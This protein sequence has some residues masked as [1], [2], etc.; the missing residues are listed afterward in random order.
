M[1]SSNPIYDEMT[2]KKEKDLVQWVSKSTIKL[3][4]HLALIYW[5]ILLL[6][7]DHA[8][9]AYDHIIR[10]K[11]SNLLH[12][13]G[14]CSPLLMLA[15]NILPPCYGGSQYYPVSLDHCPSETVFMLNQP[16]TQSVR[17][18]RQKLYRI[19]SS[20][21]DFLRLIEEFLHPIFTT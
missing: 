9:N 17:Y 5:Q 21:H 15:V 10:G 14:Q 2:K 6:H 8:K 19:S 4:K 13:R 11:I 20:H 7:R 16:L 1:Y 18:G 12:S 3:H